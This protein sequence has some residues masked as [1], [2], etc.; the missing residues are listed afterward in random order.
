MQKFVS[1]VSVAVMCAGIAQAQSVVYEQS[2]AAPNLSGPFATTNH[3]NDQRI[4]D[5]FTLAANS[6]VS[7]LTWWGWIYDPASPFDRTLGTVDNFVIQFYEAD[8]V[9]GVPGTFIAGETITMANITASVFG[10][11]G[12]GGDTFEFTASLATPVALNAGTQYWV[13]INATMANTGVWDPIYTWLWQGA[14]GGTLGDGSFAADGATGP[15]DGIWEGPLAAGS[16]NGLSFQL[17]AGV[18]LD[19]DADGLSDADEAIYGTNPLNPDTDGDGL[20]DGTEVDLAI[21]G[22][23]LDP[24]NADSDGDTLFDGTEVALGTDPCNVDTDGDGLP[25]ALDPNPTNPDIAMGDFEYVTRFVADEI[26]ATD[27]SL[28]TGNNANASKG[29]RNSLST[30][31]HNAANAIARGD[32][33]TAAD[34]LNGVYVRLDGDPQPKDWMAP[35]AEQEALAEYVLLL[36]TIALGG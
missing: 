8:G 25:D 33:A 6:S 18:I 31:V 34:L 13:A 16:N 12:F 9:G 35:S 29:K 19:T 14:G 23:C 22:S 5:D 24:L 7:D 2:P 21:A 26:A 10:G 4:A 20:L 17:T 36:L 28:F 11:S 1:T 3:S 30:R 15:F 32:Y 27:T